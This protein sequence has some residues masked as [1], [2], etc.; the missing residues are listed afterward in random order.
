[1]HVSKRAGLLIKIAASCIEKQVNQDMKEHDITG[2]QLSVLQHLEG[3]GE[4]LP[5]RSI[6][7]AL[8][9]S[10]PTAL[11]LVRRLEKKDY[12][13]TCTCAED[14]RVMLVGIT[15]TGRTICREANRQME[16]FEDRMLGGMSGEERDQFLILL[17]RALSNICSCSSGSCKKEETCHGDA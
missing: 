11:G 1:M 2:S 3:A 6:E 9:I 7:T 15:E 16:Q 8:H 12:V 17:E 13:S 10:Q 5:M 14:R 4:L